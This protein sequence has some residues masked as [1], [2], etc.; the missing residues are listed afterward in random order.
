MPWPRF[1]SEPYRAVSPIRSPPTAGASTIQIPGFMVPSCTVSKLKRCSQNRLEASAM[2]CSSSQAEAMPPAPTNSAIATRTR[3]RRSVLKS[4]YRAWATADGRELTDLLQVSGLAR[5]GKM[6]LRK[7]IAVRYIARQQ[8]MADRMAAIR[9]AQR[10]PFLS[11]RLIK[12][13]LSLTTR[14]AHD[15]ATRQGA[16]ITCRRHRESVPRRR[17]C[18]PG[19]IS[20]RAT[21][22]SR[23]QR[24]RRAGG[25]ADLAAA[26]GAAR[27]QGVF[28]GPPAFGGR[29]GDISADTES[30]G[31]RAGRPHEQARSLGARDRSG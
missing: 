20:L 6:L 16:S 31:G 1:L 23:L 26:P 8:R 27:H 22:V 11:G 13:S 17:L 29:L 25:G 24:A 3:T 19:T 5:C 4:P 10:A 18:G 7:Y 2:A 12:N 28:A 30:L 14:R 9:S 15:P 21:Q